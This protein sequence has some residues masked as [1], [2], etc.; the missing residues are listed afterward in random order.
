MMLKKKK[1]KLVTGFSIFKKTKKNIFSNSQFEKG[2]YDNP[3]LR[4]SLEQFECIYIKDKKKYNLKDIT[5]LLGYGLLYEAK[6]ILNQ[7]K[8]KL[9]KLSNHLITKIIKGFF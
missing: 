2:N 5:I 7:K 3:I 4:S 1:Y 6:K 8:I 9:S